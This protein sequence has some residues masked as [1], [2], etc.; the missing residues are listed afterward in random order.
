MRWKLKPGARAILL[1]ERLDAMIA[2]LDNAVDA[3]AESVET[4]PTT[5]RFMSCEQP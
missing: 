4:F 1:D 3:L 2:D 5:V